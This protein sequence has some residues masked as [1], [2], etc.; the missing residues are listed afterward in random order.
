[1][2]HAYAEDYLNDAMCNLGEAFDYALECQRLEL[3]AFLSLF[4]VSGL[5]ERFGE[6]VPQYVSGMSGTELVLETLRR[7]GLPAVAAPRQICYDFSSAYWCGWILAYVQWRGE[8]RFAEIHALLPVAELEGLYPTLHEVGE[9]CA[10]DAI[11]EI[12]K[13]RKPVTNLQRLRKSCRMTQRRL[14]ER[15]G[16]NL[17]TL[18]QYELGAKDINRAAGETLFSLSR[19]LGCRM[20]DLLEPKFA[21]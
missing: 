3:D 14:S 4:I 5:A 11:A 2:T 13:G 19:T 21:P 20:D 15:S 9:D 16:V 12:L 10:A 18:Q 1:M 17:R 7:A 8:W 6:G